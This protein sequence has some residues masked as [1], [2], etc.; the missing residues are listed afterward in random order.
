MAP[1]RLSL[2][3][4]SHVMAEDSHPTR[5]RLL[6]AGLALAES[7]SLASTSVNDI[8]DAAGVSK[9]AFYVHF[10][11]RASYLAALHGRFYDAVNDRVQAAMADHP[12]GAERLRRGT[13]AYLDACLNARGVRAMLLDVRSEPAIAA[14]IRDNVAAFTRQATADFKALRSSDPA[15]TAKLFVAMVHEVAMTELERAGEDRP[16]RRALWR[17]GRL[18]TAARRG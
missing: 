13:E 7:G 18:D 8:I 15:A 6:D 10:K 9:G 16:L 11:D 14:R 12:P 17:V 2:T 5:G 3:F 1:A 4:G